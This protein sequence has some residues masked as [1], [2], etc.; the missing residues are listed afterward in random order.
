MKRKKNIS[1]SFTFRM[2]YQNLPAQHSTTTI[3]H[4]YVFTVCIMNATGYNTRKFE[5]LKFVYNVPIPQYQLCSRILLTSITSKANKSFFGQNNIYVKY[6]LEVD[7]NCT[8]LHT[9]LMEIINLIVVKRSLNFEFAKVL[10][11]F[12][13]TLEHLNLVKQNAYCIFI[14]I[15]I[16]RTFVFISNAVITANIWVL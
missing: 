6:A 8:D 15:F 16:F 1:F 10:I 5:H 4:V 13:L 9:T 7:S 3:H 2:K 14:R 11:S 12:Q